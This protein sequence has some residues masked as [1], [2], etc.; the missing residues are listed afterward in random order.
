MFALK[1]DIACFKEKALA[2][3][4]LTL[5]ISHHIKDGLHLVKSLVYFADVGEYLEAKH[6]N[7]HNQSSLKVSGPFS[8]RLVSSDDNLVLK[9]Q[10]WFEELTK[11]RFSI[12]WYLHKSIPIAAGLGGGSSDAGAA[13][14]ILEN[15]SQKKL[16]T[17]QIKNLVSLGS[18]VPACYYA[19]TAMMEHIG[20][21]ITPIKLAFKPVLV[22]VNPNIDISSK[23]MFDWWDQSDFKNDDTN[24]M[25]M[26]QPISISSIVAARNDFEKI[27]CHHFSKIK[28]LLEQIGGY[29]GCVCARLSGSGS[30]CL[31]LFVDVKKAQNAFIKL[32]KNFS[33]VRIVPYFD[34]HGADI[35]DNC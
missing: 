27:A 20:N 17:E 31:G 5:E 14:R 13:I 29:D 15:I 22:L 8:N 19:Q 2:K 1:T 26:H 6:S 33:W 7:T 23:E 28:D 3:I 18:D 34:H 30:T 10:K 21:K 24:Q 11:C 9:A 25:L 16:S 32:Q 12:D 35:N 4:N